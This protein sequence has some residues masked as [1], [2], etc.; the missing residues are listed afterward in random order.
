V[1]D[2]FFTFDVEV[3]APLRHDRTFLKGQGETW[4]S[5]L[6]RLDKAKIKTT[7]FVTGEFAQIYPALFD[8][9]VHSGHEIAS[10]TMTHRPYFSIGDK[11]FELEIARSKT[12]LEDHAQKQVI[13]F[14]APLGQ[15]PSHLVSLLH[16]HGYAYDSSIAATH[17]PGHFQALGTPRRL[18]HPAFDEVREEDEC[19]SFWEIPI[20][21]TPMVP[22][23]Y[24]GFFLSFVASVAWRFP[25]TKQ[26]PHVMFSHP[27]DFMDMRKYRGCY[28]W[29]R[30]KITRNNWRMLAHF[31]RERHGQ[32]ARLSTFLKSGLCS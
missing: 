21:I 5:I 26:R 19:S 28:A 14:R 1:S 2:L 32:D 18:Y 22:L 12:F 25:Q 30:F 6:S 8:E 16:K 20:A 23:P 13:G 15:I 11:E 4:Q 24:G 3:Y 7:F 31:C 17:I 9:M 10:H 29:D 27:H